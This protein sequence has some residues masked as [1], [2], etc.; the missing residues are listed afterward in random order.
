M[1]FLPHIFFNFTD[2]SSEVFHPKCKPAKNW[3]T[4]SKDQPVRLRLT[5]DGI[6]SKTPETVVEV[7]SKCV[8]KYPN[9]IAM[10]K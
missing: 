6:N 5:K 7:F 4:W 9:N 2:G 3:F 10:S 8:E 1:F